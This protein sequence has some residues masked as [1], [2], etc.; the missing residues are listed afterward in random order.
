MNGLNKNR[1]T[2]KPTKSAGTRIQGVAKNLM[3][4]VEAEN[5]SLCTHICSLHYALNVECPSLQ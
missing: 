5:S 1:G 3:E 2:E 4:V